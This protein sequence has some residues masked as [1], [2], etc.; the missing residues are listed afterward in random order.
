MVPSETWDFFD[1][2]RPPPNFE[3]FTTETWDFFDFLTIFGL[4]LKFRCFFDWKASLSSQKIVIWFEICFQTSNHQNIYKMSNSYIK[5]R[6]M[7]DENKKEKEWH[8]TLYNLWKRGYFSS[9]KIVLKYKIFFLSKSFTGWLIKLYQIHPQTL[10][11]RFKLFTR[12]NQV[13]IYP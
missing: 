3:L 7:F 13:M 4:I 8:W 1:F 11:I 12:S 5:N 10:L 6:G 9:Y 2:R